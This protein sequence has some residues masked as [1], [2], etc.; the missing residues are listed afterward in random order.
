[1]YNFRSSYWRNPIGVDG[2]NEGYLVYLFHMTVGR[3]GTFLLFPVL[4]LGVAGFCKALFD[5]KFPLRIVVLSAGIAF[6]IMTTFYI[7]KTNNYIL[8]R[9]QIKKLP[10]F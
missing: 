6:I 9:L 8:K 10:E 4:L 1:M 3:F 2:M 7:I 5:R